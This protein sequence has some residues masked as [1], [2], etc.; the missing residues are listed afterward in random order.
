LVYDPAVIYRGTSLWLLAAEGV[1]AISA[2][3]FLVWLALQVLMFVA[4]LALTLV[5][6]FL[7]WWAWLELND[8]LDRGRPSPS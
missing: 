1:A 7:L 6:A 2:A 5:V 8:R 4:V 3:A